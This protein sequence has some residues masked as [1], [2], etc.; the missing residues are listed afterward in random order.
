[1]QPTYLESLQVGA[2]GAQLEIQVYE[3]NDE[4]RLDEIVDISGADTYSIVVQ[5]PDE[6][7]FT[8]SATFSSDGTDGK[9]YIVTEATDLTIAGT[10]Y[11]Q[12][13]ISLSVW[14][15]RSTIGQFEVKENLG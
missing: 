6:T 5:R 12:G 9:I 4:T 1:M 7:T 10:Y 14:Q 13:D 3:Y 15:G 11:I 8:R 2:V